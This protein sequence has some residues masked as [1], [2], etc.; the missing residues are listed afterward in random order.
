MI[1]KVENSPILELVNVTKSFVK[2]QKLFE[3]INISVNKSQIIALTGKNGSGKSTL[4]KIIA[5]LDNDYIGTIKY[6]GNDHTVACSDI[7]YI[8]QSY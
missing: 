2:E 7:M 4:L 8:H 3:N 6:N 5:G 1:E